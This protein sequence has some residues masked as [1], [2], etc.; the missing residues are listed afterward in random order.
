MSMHVKCEGI[1]TCEEDEVAVVEAAGGEPW[2]EHADGVAGVGKHVGVAEVGGQ[3][4]AP[5]RGHV[6][7]RPARLVGWLAF[8]PIPSASATTTTLRPSSTYI[9]LNCM[10]P[11][12]RRRARRARGCRRRRR[13]RGTGPR[14]AP[15]RRPPHPGR[16]GPGSWRCPP[17]RRWSRSGSAPTRRTPAYIYRRTPAGEHAH[18][19]T[20][21]HVK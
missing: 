20:D 9:Q 14:A 10:L 12:R 2:S 19:H 6:E 5:P 21:R 16:G 3:P 17:R 13:R 7:R 8:I 18:T 11:W 4:V 1:H 15:W